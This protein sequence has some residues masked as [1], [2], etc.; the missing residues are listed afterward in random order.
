[1]AEINWGLAQTPDYFGGAMRSQQAGQAARA[2]Q[3]KAQA[4]M[5]YSQNPEAG[6]KAIMQFDPATGR[7]LVSDQQEQAQKAQAAAFRARAA[8][9]YNNGD[10]R[11]AQQVLMQAGEP[12]S[13]VQ[14]LGQDDSVQGVNLGSGGFATFD[15]RTRKFEVLRQPEAQPF[16]M[17]PEKNYWMPDPEP[18]PG[19]AQQGGGGFEDFFSKH[20]APAEGGYAP[21]DGNGQPVNFGINQ[22]SNPDVDVK[23]LTPARAKQ[24]TLER[25]W[26]P[27]GADQLPPALAAIQADTAFNMGVGTA[28]RMLQESGG[29][30]NKYMAMREQKYRAIAQADPGKARYLPTW[31]NRNQS[32]AGYVQG[33]GQQSSGTPATGPA[34]PAGMRLVQAAQPKPREQWEQLP[35]GRLRSTLTNDIK[36][37]A[38][39]AASKSTRATEANLRKEFNALPDVKNYRT[40]A[41]QAAAVK[42][43]AAAPPS[44]NGDIAM[45]YAV[46]KSYDP[47]SVVRETEFATAQNAAGVPDKI[48]NKFN[49]IRN[50]QRLNPEQRAEMAATVAGFADTY[51]QRYDTVAEEY[52]GYAADY[53]G[54]PNRV[55]PLAKESAAP[56]VN[57]PA[58]FKARKGANGKFYAPDPN[59]PKSFPEV[60]L[61]ADGAWRMKSANGQTLKYVP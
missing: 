51:K 22:G 31:L 7:Q 43:L 12:I 46:M 40:V 16:G 13:G 59:N 10:I 27:S 24:I 17:D 2:E 61:G 53:S 36:G 32:L 1:M 23:N 4:Y 19:V 49:A 26:K 33:L 35:D 50:G 18:P 3:A 6:A 37:E 14:A 34:G 52:R 28:R 41:T 39:G 25:Y 5:L 29:D 57:P 9:L 48:R 11:G 60:T 38:T 56:A 42:R 8:E 54:D 55:V 20:L 45:V 47:T 21:N 44:A 30:P 15:K 58:E